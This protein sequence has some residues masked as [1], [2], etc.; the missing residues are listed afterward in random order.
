MSDK[1]DKVEEM[2]NAPKGG[3]LFEKT[4]EEVISTL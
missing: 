2:L 3:H 4:V 1:K